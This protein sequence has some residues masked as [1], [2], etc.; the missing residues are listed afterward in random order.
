MGMYRKY[1]EPAYGEVAPEVWIR[2]PQIMDMDH[3]DEWRRQSDLE[4]VA[5]ITALYKKCSCYPEV[6]S[7]RCKETAINGPDGNKIP[8]RI[9]L[10][11]NP[12]KNPCGVLVFYH[13]G[14]FCINNLDVYEY[15]NRYLSCYGNLII[16]VP[17]YRLAPECPFPGGLEDA[18]CTLLWT[19]E[20]I[21]EYGGDPSRISVAGDS[22]GGNFAAAV[23]L[24]ARDRQG[25]HI[26]KQVMVYPVTTNV[27]TEMTESEKHYSKGYFLEYNMTE[28]P[29]KCY[30][31][32]KEDKYNPLASPLLAEE[33]TDLPAACFI[34]AECDPLL[35][36]GLMYAAK[37]EDHKVPVEC[38]VM[39]GMIHG[40]LNWTY[41]ESFKAMQL[42]ADFV[43]Q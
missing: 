39:K 25:P 1:T 23:S 43:N 2:E 30:F 4:T 41:G 21:K 33:L 14:G 42:A 27:G 34:L 10:P 11:K 26:E 13:G 16:V 8:V 5:D 6:M 3:R 19:K 37:L 35:D 20:H 18:Y 31:A 22:S 17:E 12:G 15:V 28:E 40:F 7:V 38:H 9:F 32:K 36:Q 24:M 29:T